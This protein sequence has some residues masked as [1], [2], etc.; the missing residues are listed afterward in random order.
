ML[1][2]VGMPPDLVGGFASMMK[3]Q[4]PELT[5]RMAFGDS[6]EMAAAVDPDFILHVGPAWTGGLYRTTLVARA[7]MQLLGSRAYLA[8]RGHPDSLAAIREHPLLA[9]DVP[10]LD[11]TA[12][13]LISGDTLAVAPW[14]VSKDAHLVRAMVNRGEGLALLPQTDATR[15]VPGEDLE[16]VLPEQVG[17]H[18]QLRALIPESRAGSARCRAVSD[19]MRLIRDTLPHLQDPGEEP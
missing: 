19:M 3:A 14:F 11:P 12:L 6:L 8:R 16:A 4:H 13:P 1:I 10:E 15:G 5:L 17:A 18:I 9:W 7:P 2:P